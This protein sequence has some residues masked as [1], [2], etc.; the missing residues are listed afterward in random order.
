MPTLLQLLEHF[1]ASLTQNFASQIPGQPED[2]LKPAVKS[3][4]ESAG[5]ELNRPTLLRSE[6]TVQGLGGRPDFGVDVK[7]ALCGHIELKAPGLGGRPQK[8]PSKSRDAGQWKKFKSLPNLIYTDGNEWSLFHGGEQVGA[9]VR[10]AG[11]VTQDGAG[12]VTTQNAAL[13]GLLREFLGWE[14]IVPSRPRDLARLLAPLCQLIRADVQNAVADADSSL[15]L[16]AQAWRD[17]L[18][19]DAD[20]AKFADAYAQTLTYGLL[21][22]R[23]EGQADLTL[24]NAATALDANHGLLAESLRVLG[25]PNARRDIGT[26][27]EVL[28]RVLNALQ[29]DLWNRDDQQGDGDPWLYFYEEFLAAYDP[30]LRADAGVYYTP[31]QVVRAQVRLIDELLRSPR[32]GKPRGFNAPGVTVLDPASG[33]GAYP[34]AVLE[35]ALA[36]AKAR[37]GPG[38]LAGAATDLAARLNAFEFLVGPYAVA[39][40]RLTQAVRAAGGHLPAEGRARLPVRHAGI[41]VRAHAAGVLHAASGGRA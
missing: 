38:A 11:D 33:T 8:F 22:A 21:L 34:L 36:A 31:V 29:P 37:S 15:S 7:G 35:H 2:Q 30:K 26:G 4:L 3:L 13:D 10:L 41:P 27:L 16:L 6:S 24:D 20:N 19:P 14:P 12:A 25:H 39:H 40:L 18:F 17:A 32:F 23:V 5:Q 28:L 1:A 9:T